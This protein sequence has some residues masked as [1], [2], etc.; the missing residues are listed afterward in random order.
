MYFVV[1]IYEVA[2]FCSSIFLEF[3]NIL[4][5]Q[6]KG[7]FTDWFF[8]RLDLGSLLGR[9]VCQTLHKMCAYNL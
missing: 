4:P 9:M 2:H 6:K 5:R 3:Q 7:D 1:A 8:T